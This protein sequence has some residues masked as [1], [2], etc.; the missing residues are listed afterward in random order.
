MDTTPRS[1]PPGA[2]ERTVTVHWGKVGALV[3]GQAVVQGGSFALLIAMNWTA[4]QMGGASA[5]SMLMLAATI[6][7]ALMLIFGGAVSDVLGPRFVLLRTTAARAVVLAVGALVAASSTH[8]WPLMIVALVEGALLGLAG[9]A[10]GVL[11]PQLASREHLGRANSLYAMVLRLAPIIGAPIGA[12]LISVGELWQALLAASLT[13]VFWLGCLLYVTRGFTA[14]RREPGVSMFKRSGDGFQLLVRNKRLRWMFLAS[15]CLD[16]AFGWPA[17]VALPSLV[18]QRGWGVGAVGVV[19]AAFSVGALGSSA[20][21]AVMAHRISMFVRMVVT[22]VGLAFG[23]LVMA[24]MP[25]VLSLTLVTAGVGLL[26]GLNGPAIVTVYQQSAPDSRMG[27]A[28]STLSLSGIGTGPISIAVFSSLSLGL[29]VQ[30]TW[31]ICGAIAFGSPLAAVMALRQ[32]VQLE[33]PTG[34]AVP[35]EENVRTEPAELLAAE[36]EFAPE[37]PSKPAHPATR[38]TTTTGTPQTTGT[39]TAGTA[40]TAD[41]APP[42]PADVQEPLPA[43]V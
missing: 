30:T 35:T 29:G 40:R 11:M 7:R 42:V 3:S 4:V 15:F 22:G 34:T 25:T 2:A 26:S 8:L 33:E 19:L 5:V 43:S 17:D 38:V 21:G 12:W 23:I 39:Q 36:A 10:S 20:L 1:A 27:A 6:P 28:M 31:L 14:P 37:A 24:L 16:L 41:T 9:P 18:S 32:P 13:G